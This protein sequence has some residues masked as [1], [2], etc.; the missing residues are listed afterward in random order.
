M[1]DV[2]LTPLQGHLYVSRTYLASLGRW[3]AYLVQVLSLLVK[4]F[5]LKVMVVDLGPEAALYM[6]VSVAGI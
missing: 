3:P 5:A 2:N 6:A 4:G 1:A